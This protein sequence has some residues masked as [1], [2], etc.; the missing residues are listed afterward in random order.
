MSD[1]RKGSSLFALNRR[2]GADRRG[3]LRY[4]TRGLPV[5]VIWHQ[6]DRRGC[7]QGRLC[8]LSVSGAA[9]LTEEPLPAGAKVQIRL[10]TDTA[11]APVEGTAIRVTK[12]RRFLA[13]PLVISLRF[14]EPCPYA[15]FS[16][17]VCKL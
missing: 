14:A 12:T 10:E 2:T 16:A 3:A 6:G 11:V 15:F 8:D 4:D 9:L 17:A 5:W 7:G 1:R 13:G